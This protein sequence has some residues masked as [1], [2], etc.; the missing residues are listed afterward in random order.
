MSRSRT[1]AHVFAS[2]VQPGEQTDLETPMNRGDFRPWTRPMTNSGS[3]SLNKGHVDAFPHAN[4]LDER[5]R[6]LLYMVNRAASEQ[7]LTTLEL[8]CKFSGVGVLHRCVWFSCNPP[9]LWGTQNN[10]KRAL[11]EKYQPITAAYED[12]ARKHEITFFQGRKC[13]HLLRTWI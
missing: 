7:T 4:A 2:L 3:D 1:F 5:A 9:P 13:H 12:A 11:T 6:E 10:V 8:E